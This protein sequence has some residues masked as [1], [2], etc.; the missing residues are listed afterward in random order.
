VVRHSRGPATRLPAGAHRRAEWTGG[1]AHLGP[2]SQRQPHLDALAIVSGPG[3]PIAG[4]P[5]QLHVLGQDA[6]GTLIE[7]GAL[8]WRSADSAVA[9]IDSSGFLVPR[10]PGMVRIS[11][12][13]G[14]WRAATASVSVRVS[15]TRMVLD[16]QWQAGF[17]PAW[18]AFG[19][20]AP[21]LERESDGDAS[22]AI[23][24]AGLY[25]TGIYLQRGLL[26]RDGISVDAELSMRATLSGRAVA[27]C[28]GFLREGG[29]NS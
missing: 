20:P 29:S 18:R 17:T 15:D 2:D 16:E 1:G 21:Q 23:T 8:T 6:S 26:P 7:P 10:R 12:S 4:V 25:P 3:K 27:V 28:R 22:I 11:V 9:T 14:G 5:H 13:S 24:G 19:T